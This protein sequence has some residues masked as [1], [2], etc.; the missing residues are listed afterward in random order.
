MKYVASYHQEKVWFIDDFERGT[1]YSGGPAYHNI[2]LILYSKLELNV[3]GIKKAFQKLCYTHEVLRT[4][5]LEEEG[6]IYQSI[7]DEVDDT[8]EVF[9]LQ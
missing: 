1:I 6:I 5:I 8:V 3:S 4:R 2:P 7:C 9:N